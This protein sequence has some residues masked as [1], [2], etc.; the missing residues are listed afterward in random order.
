VYYDKY[1]RDIIAV[2]SQNIGVAFMSRSFIT[3]LISALLLITWPV[4][5]AAHA[6]M[7]KS[8]PDTNSELTTPP[9]KVELWFSEGVQAEW[10]KIEVTDSSGNR[11]DKDAVDGTKDEPN[12]LHV[13]LNGVHSGSYNVKWSTLSHDGHRVKGEYSFTVK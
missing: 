13:K 2:F 10:S 4:I 12:Y 9:Q 11:V 7:E 8:I 3:T 6:H 1:F 5:S